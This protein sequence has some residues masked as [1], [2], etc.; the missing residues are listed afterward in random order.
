MHQMSEGLR[1][2]S[3]RGFQFAHPRDDQGRLIAVVGIRVHH[4][5]IDIMQVYS[6]HDAEAARIPDEEPDVLFPQM[7]LWRSTGTAHEV[8]EA[9]TALADPIPY[10]NQA[11]GRWIP[12]DAGHAT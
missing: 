2:L 7:V 4:G 3:A 1:T 9:I 12:I 5:V 6:D 11:T 10:P 8:L